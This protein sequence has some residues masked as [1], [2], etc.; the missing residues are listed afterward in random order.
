MCHTLVERLSLLSAFN[1]K[2]QKSCKCVKQRLMPR[3]MVTQNPSKLVC[4][5]A[6]KLVL[7]G[8]LFV[9]KL[10]S[11][12]FEGSFYKLLVVN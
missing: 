7:G 3:E 11:V 4:V 8:F 1:I 12:G 2:T 10:G 6:S 5:L 9:V